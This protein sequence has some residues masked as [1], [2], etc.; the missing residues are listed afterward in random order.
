MHEPASRIR[1]VMDG[2]PHERWR[3]GAALAAILVLGSCADAPPPPPPRVQWL[4]AEPTAVTVG[5]ET[6]RA[7]GLGAQFLYRRVGALAEMPP[8]LDLPADF[9]AATAVI[10]DYRLWE[11]RGP[12]LRGVHS[13]G[14]R[15]EVV[16]VQTAGAA[17]TVPLAAWSTFTAT[18][19]V[20]V[21]LTVLP[22]LRPAA[23]SFHWSAMIPA[24]AVLEFGFALREESWNER[25]APVRFEITVMDGN[26]AP[27]TLFEQTLDPRV[28]D[29]RHWFDAR[30]D[31]GALAG[32][33][34]TFEFTARAVD[35]GGIFAPTWSDPMV[36]TRAPAP[37]RPNVLVV[38]FDTLRA[39]NLGCYG[40]PRATSPFIDG[41]AAQGTLFEHAFT[42]SA[43]TGPSH[44][45]LFTGRYPPHHGIRRGIESKT[46]GV[47]T[48]AELLR[49]AGYLTAAFTENGFIIRDR[50]F[51]DGFSSYTE[52]AGESLS[53]VPGE[54]EATFAQARRWIET[55]QQ[56]PFFL[57]VHTY[58]VHN[59]YTPPAAY[60]DLFHGQPA[61]TEPVVDPVPAPFRPYRDAYDREIRF[62]DQA[63]RT[64]FEGLDATG[65]AT[66]TLV[67]LL[68]DHG[69]E[70]GEHGG[71]QHGAAVFDE[72]LRVPLIFWAPGR[73]PAGARSS[74][75]VSLIDVAPT[76]LDLAGIAI[77]AGL[78]GVTLR[79]VLVSGETLGPRTLFGEAH[80][81][82]RWTA[83]LLPQPFNPPVIGVL[84]EDTKYVVHRPTQGETL[85]TVAY[86]LREDPFEQRPEPMPTENQRDVDRLVD[87]YLTGGVAPGRGALPQS[88]PTA[89]PLDPEVREKLRLLGYVD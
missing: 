69:E 73:V 77:P 87:D 57:F 30:V 65:L 8:T 49:T 52:N 11:Q 22:V 37:D 33:R 27:R 48:L 4:L 66:S 62:V 29:T 61:V 41:I 63:T 23:Q 42:T 21:A 10:V 19:P 38:S 89:E 6:R 25:G 3:I 18:T 15:T 84:A 2:A 70:F 45:S 75:R 60:A 53:A 5:V 50:G 85:P 86:R 78:D 26:G 88:M 74:A 9:G 71:F 56:R 51:G 44:M 32:R 43:T 36:A 24:D 46:P 68:A 58:E 83:P 14:Q 31:L 12:L 17:R 39:R 72:V 34:G 1:D 64:L 79:T 16:D 7:T 80:A 81:N 47:A 67:L 28:A 13:I 40:Y 55:N 54:A 20:K 35:G 59:P 76:V 82:R